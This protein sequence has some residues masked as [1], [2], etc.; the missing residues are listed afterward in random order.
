MIWSHCIIFLTQIGRVGYTVD[1][2]IYSWV[3][4]SLDSVFKIH[5]VKMIPKSIKI[6]SLQL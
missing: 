3:L 2:R 1:N 6:I 5:S 4:S